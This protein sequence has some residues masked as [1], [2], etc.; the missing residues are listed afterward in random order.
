MIPV[1]H[2]TGKIQTK[3]LESHFKFLQFFM[4]FKES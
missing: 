1:Y 3:K 4:E 2:I